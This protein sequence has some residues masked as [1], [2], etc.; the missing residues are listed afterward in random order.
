MSSMKNEVIRRDVDE[1]EQIK[2]DAALELRAAAAAEED[3]VALQASKVAHEER[4]EI[5]KE[6]SKKAEKAKEAFEKI[7]KVPPRNK[8]KAAKVFCQAWNELRTYP[9]SDYSFHNEKIKLL[10]E[11]QNN[12]LEM[13]KDNNLISVLT[14]KGCKI[15]DVNWGLEGEDDW[16]SL[17]FRTA[18]GGQR[19]KTKKAKI[20]RKHKKTKK[21]KKKGKKIKN[22][23][24]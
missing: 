5:L 10:E 22:K 11:L 7:E 1:K 18:H 15:K 6:Y 9:T 8:E 19:K 2:R 13:V 20:K 3:K 14:K 17:G 24:E 23:K 4:E 12:F 21:S 16:Y